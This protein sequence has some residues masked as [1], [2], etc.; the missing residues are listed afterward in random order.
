MGRESGSA[1]SSK[2]N[3]EVNLV[4]CMFCKSDAAICREV[5]PGISMK[6]TVHGEH[7]LMTEFLLK[8]GSILPAHK[9]VHEQT[10]LPDFRKD[11]SYYRK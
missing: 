2:I 6:T 10:G 3:T 7:T 9:H 1:I 11:Y 5:F 8:K 4:N